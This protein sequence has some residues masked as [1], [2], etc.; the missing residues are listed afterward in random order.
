MYELIGWQEEN[1]RLHSPIPASNYDVELP[2]QMLASIGYYGFWNYYMNTGD[3]ETIKDLYAGA[4][5]YLKMWSFNEDGSLVVRNTSW[6]WGDWE[7]I[8]IKRLCLMR[9]II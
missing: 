2:G 9:G 6:V 7:L 8:L 5:E 3:L 4:R 1:G